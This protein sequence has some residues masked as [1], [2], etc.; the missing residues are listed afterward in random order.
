MIDA[1]DLERLRQLAYP[2]GRVWRAGAYLLGLLGRLR[3]RFI[4]KAVQERL[5]EKGPAILGA[6]VL[7]G[8]LLVL[9]VLSAIYAPRLR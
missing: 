9:G 8:A 4:E 3:E 5:A 7:V 1:Q 6:G 2:A